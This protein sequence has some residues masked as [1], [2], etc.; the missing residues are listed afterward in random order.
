MVIKFKGFVFFGV[1]G[2]RKKWYKI[3]YKKHLKLKGV[4]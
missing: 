4:F 3:S 2:I 1:I